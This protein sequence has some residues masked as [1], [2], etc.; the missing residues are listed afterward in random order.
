M[1]L[2]PLTSLPRSGSTLLMSILGQN[3]KFS[4]GND[5]EIGNL[6]NYNK[7]FIIKNIHHFQLP[8]EVVSECFYDF[9][10]KGTEAWISKISESEKIFLDKSRH[11][12]KDPD[13]FFHMFPDIKMIINI[14]DLRGVV[15]SFEKINNN[16]LFI[17]KSSFYNQI[18]F[19]LQYQRVQNI[20]NISYLR[21]GLISIKELI[22][23]PKTFKNK[24]HIC[25][26][27]LLLDDP[28]TELKK[29]YEFLDIPKFSHNFDQIEQKHHNDNPYQPY[30]VHKISPKLE[31]KSEIFPHLRPDISQE[32]ISEYIWYYQTF[33]PEV[34]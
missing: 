30:G 14:R 18:N 32:I 2:L 9:C 12:L 15:N 19:D 13:Y 29:I 10:R 7:E 22:D 28:L 5:S 20:F 4:I 8:H 21:E 24:I 17:D 11:W 27:E 1:N 25:K 23:I 34:L 16:S 33:Y 3:P 26:Y 31:K 6:L